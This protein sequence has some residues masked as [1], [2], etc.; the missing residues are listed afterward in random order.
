VRAGHRLRFWTEGGSSA[1]LLTGEHLDLPLGF[2]S[3][4]ATGSMLGTRVLHIFDGTTLGEPSEL[5]CA[6]QARMTLIAAGPA[7]GAGLT[8]RETSQ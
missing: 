8:R 6:P 3:I 2:E 4:G 1:S 7:A 5:P